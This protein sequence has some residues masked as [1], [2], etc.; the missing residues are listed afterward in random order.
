VGV[1]GREISTVSTAK[2]ISGI[3]GFISFLV[4]IVAMTGD[5]H[6]ATSIMGNSV[7]KSSASFPIL[8][9]PSDSGLL[10]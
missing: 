7:G 3:S 6:T 2:Q 5:V 9:D 4:D 10:I 8:S 1:T